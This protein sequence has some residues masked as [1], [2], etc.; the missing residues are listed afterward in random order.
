MGRVVE[1]EARRRN[2]VPQI[3]ARLAARE[4]GLVRR[5]MGARW[6]FGLAGVAACAAAAYF[7][8]VPRQR[9]LSY[10]VS[11]SAGNGALATPLVASAAAPLQLSFSDGSAV[12][13]PARGAAHVDAL[14]RDGATVAIE[15]GTLEVSVV[16]RTHTHWQVRAGA[17]RIAVTGTRFAAGWDRAAQ[18]LTV[19]MHEGSVMVSGPGLPEPVRVVTGQ[20]LLASA[21]GADLKLAGS[22]SPSAALEA[23]EAAPG[24]VEAPA[25]PAAEPALAPPAPELTPSA[26]ELTPAPGRTRSHHAEVPTIHIAGSTGADWR[27]AAARARYHDALAAAVLEGWRAECARL[28][29]DDLVLLGDVARLAGD[30]DRAEEAYQAARRRFPSADRPVFALGLIAFE[31]RHDYGRA[32]DLFASY[33]RGFPRGPL[34]RE[35]AGRLIESRLKAGDESGARQ[36]ATEYLHDF[37]GGPHAALARR[38]LP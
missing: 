36:A 29:P 1:G 23:S 11:G 25:G 14:D 22:A 24:R 18:T 37:P 8:V 9:T 5:P 31:G 3:Q 28:G 34:A 6:A 13:I 12:T 35:A 33:L 4:A 21:S 20:R 38:A 26:P 30:L 10:A 27:V 2:L 16:H 15:E 7:V 17:Y 19:T 32:G